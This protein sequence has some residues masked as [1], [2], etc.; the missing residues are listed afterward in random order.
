[1]QAIPRSLRPRPAGGDPPDVYGLLTSAAGRNAV[2]LL[3]GDGEKQAALR[4]GLSRHT[5]HEYVGELYRRFGVCSRPEL[6]A[7]CLRR[8]L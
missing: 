2:C 8:R 1:M 5:V 7:L 4:L 3:E 6:M